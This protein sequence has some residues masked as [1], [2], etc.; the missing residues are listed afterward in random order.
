MI[1]L[2]ALDAPDR[3]PE[4]WAVLTT[5]AATHDMARFYVGLQQVCKW[6]RRRFDGF[7]YASVIEYTTGYGERSGGERRPHWNLLLKGVPVSEI[8]RAGAIIRDH[9]CRHVDARPHAQSVDPVWSHGG[10]LGYLAGHVEKESQKPPPGWR[11]QR[12]NCSRDYFEGRTRA[13]MRSAARA[14]IALRTLLWRAARAQGLE[15]DAAKAAAKAWEAAGA[16]GTEGLEGDAAKAWAWVAA[17]QER[18]DGVEWLAVRIDP[19]GRYSPLEGRRKPRT[20]DDDG[21]SFH[22]PLEE[23]LRMR[24]QPP[25]RDALKYAAAHDLHL[26][27]LRW[28]SQCGIVAP[29]IDAFQ[30]KQLDEIGFA[31]G[32]CPDCRLGLEQA[33]EARRAA[34]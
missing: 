16:D 12:F 17:E 26:E 24:R 22:S 11:G 21:G 29:A 34:S 33:L 7:G 14:K 23:H 19:D 32:L 3:A 13:E 20:N 1:A 30:R 5:R 25:S 18:L 2:D 10:L 8:D 28:C 4:V 27:Q 15:G 9:W 31:D 6:L